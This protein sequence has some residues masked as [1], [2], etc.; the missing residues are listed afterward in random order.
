MLP[1]CILIESWYTLVLHFDTWAVLA[2]LKKDT[3]GGVV[4]GVFPYD[5]LPGLPGLPWVVMNLNTSFILVCEV[6]HSDKLVPLQL[7]V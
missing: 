5:K 7:A 3:W 1:T 4:V 2:V 6:L